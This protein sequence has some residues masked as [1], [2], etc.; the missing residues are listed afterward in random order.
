MGDIEDL[1]D[2]IIDIENR[3]YNSYKAQQKFSFYE[4]LNIKKE[5]KDEF[6]NMKIIINRNNF[7]N[8]L[9]SLII[10][11]IIIYVRQGL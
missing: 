11:G 1:R 7:N 9:I 10:G 8:L 3:V 2:K 4:Y 5:L 6:T